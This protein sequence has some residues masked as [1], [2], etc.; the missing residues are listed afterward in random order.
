MSLEAPRRAVVTWTY[1]DLRLLPEDRNRYEVIDGELFVTPSPT[2]THQK[3]SK[4]IQLAFMLQV[5]NAGTGVV[6]NAPLDVIFSDTRV[7]QPDLL[8][9]AAHRRWI[10]TERGIEKAPDLVVEILSPSTCTADREVKRKLYASQGVA[11]LWL[12]DP[13]T[14]VIE[15]LVQA[16][17]GYRLH[18]SF[19]PGTRVESTVFHLDLPVDPI[20]AP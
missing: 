3:V 11:E 17:L 10:I 15:V 1:S 20:F 14:H 8:V 19:G 13:E 16:E 6:F 4:R 9:V 7:V 5:E 2:T 18:G 12:V